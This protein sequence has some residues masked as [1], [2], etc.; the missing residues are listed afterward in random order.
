MQ[1]SNGDAKYSSG[2]FTSSDK[3]ISIKRTKKN[4]RERREQRP[5]DRKSERQE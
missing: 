1:N 3:G 2:D 5:R 4:E